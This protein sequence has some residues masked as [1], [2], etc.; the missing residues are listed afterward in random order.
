MSD[1]V[2]LLCDSLAVRDSRS[3][4]RIFRPEESAAGSLLHIDVLPMFK[5]QFPIFCVSSV[6]PRFR[7]H[8]LFAITLISRIYFSR[9]HT[10]SK[11]EH[12]PPPS[13]EL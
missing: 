2:R 13:A 3:P 5:C 7:C 10:P 9:R 11:L 8:L 4:L 12:R 6:E 1:S